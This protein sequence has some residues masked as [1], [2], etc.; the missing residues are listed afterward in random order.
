VN[1]KYIIN[2]E[3]EE[4]MSTPEKRILKNFNKNYDRFLVNKK[5]RPFKK[6]KKRMNCFTLLEEENKVKSPSPETH[7]NTSV[8]SPISQN[9]TKVTFPIQENVVTI[10]N[11]NKI[12]DLFQDFLK[13]NASLIKSIV[14]SDYETQN[15]FNL[16]KSLIYFQHD[17]RQDLS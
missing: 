15:N 11:N 10:N 1:G 6:Y 13:T 4:E 12:I 5:R 9:H 3:T 2:P 16:L 7:S 14:T 17:S 8:I